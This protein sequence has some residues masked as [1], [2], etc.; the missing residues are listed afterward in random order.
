[1]IGILTYVSVVERTKEIGILRAIGARKKDITR[2]FIAEAGLI[3]FISGAVGVGVTMLLSVPISGS[4]AKALKV[5]AFTASLNAQSSIGL[6]LLS[7]ILTLIASI[8]P[9]RIAAKKD[10]VEA[11]RTE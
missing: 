5:E 8:I 4:I 9:S 7:L 3:G 6:I 2:I 11:L 10:P 1:M